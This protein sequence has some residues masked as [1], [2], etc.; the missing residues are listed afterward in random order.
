MAVP[1]SLSK[2]KTGQIKTTKSDFLPLFHVLHKEQITK[3]SQN[4]IF[5]DSALN[6]TSSVAQARFGTVF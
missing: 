1:I 4:G 2:Y 5:C 3:L 6:H